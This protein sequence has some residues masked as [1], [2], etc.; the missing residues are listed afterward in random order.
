MIT[1]AKTL[2]RSLGADPTAVYQSLSRRSIE[3]A[4][5][6]QGLRPLRDRLRDVIPDIID[7]YSGELDA[8]EYGR[9]WEAKMRGLH[10]FQIR[11]ALAAMETV[12]RDDMVVVD[13]GD[14][15]G[16]HGRYLRATAPAGRLSR[17]VSANLDPVAV[18][19]IKR[20]GGEAILCR[21]EDMALEGIE[22]DLFVTFQM[23]EHL[24][25]PVRF[26]HGLATRG[27]ADHLLVTVPYRRH[28]RFGGSHLRLPADRL[29]AKMTA[30]DVHVFEFSPADWTLLARFAGWSPVATRIYYQYPRRS[31]LAVTA[32]MWRHLDFEGFLALTLKRDLSLAE[33]Y[34]DW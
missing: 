24:T 10:A 9:L 30:E 18:E 33:H 6:E 11:E 1:L 7:Q 8:G 4:I 14:S 32:P 3:A 34:A 21:A 31:P 15:S 22:A 27:R 12:G 16:N 25:D 2:L 19:K 29:P 28:S 23:L 20:N 17:V 5:G 13:I 26:L